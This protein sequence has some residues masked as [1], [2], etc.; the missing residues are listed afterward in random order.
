MLKGYISIANAGSPNPITHET[1]FLER[2][3]FKKMNNQERPKMLW[4]EW[5]SE[6]QQIK[7]TFFFIFDKGN[8]Y[9]K[10]RLEDFCLYS[11]WKTS[12]SSK[13]K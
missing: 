13:Q 3:P 2:L 4:I 11:F 5:R 10:S 8:L 9:L 7:A 12:S 6:T 1:N